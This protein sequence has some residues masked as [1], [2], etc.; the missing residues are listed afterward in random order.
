MGKQEE[1]SRITSDR[2]LLRT[3][4]IILTVFLVFAGPTYVPYMLINVIEMDYIISMA[5][6]FC[7]FIIGLVLLIYLVRKKI[8]S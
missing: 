8:I 3:F 6:G 4:L 1:K 2:R 5:S 7:L